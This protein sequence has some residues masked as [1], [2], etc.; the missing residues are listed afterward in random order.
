LLNIEG[1]EAGWSD[2]S[3]AYLPPQDKKEAIDT[4]IRNFLEP[5]G[6]DERRET[7]RAA[8]DRIR[9]AFSK[10]GHSPYTLLYWRGSREKDGE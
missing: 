4:P 7:A 3:L 9:E 6:A 1:I 5:A 2:K 10:A 8:P